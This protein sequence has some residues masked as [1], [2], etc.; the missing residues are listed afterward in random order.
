M[1]ALYVSVRAS[2]CIVFDGECVLCVRT[3]RELQHT[4]QKE[5][6]G[7][8]RNAH[9][10]HTYSMTNKEDNLMTFQEK[11]ARKSEMAFMS[12]AL[13]WVLCLSVRLCKS[14]L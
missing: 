9:N 11:L 1:C 4:T 3:C 13:R 12:V 2:V 14:K 7:G 6:R 8:G 5:A 10:K